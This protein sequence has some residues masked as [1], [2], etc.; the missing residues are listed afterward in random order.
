MGTRTAQGAVIATRKDHPHAYGDK[1][2]ITA[3]GLR[4][5]GSSPRVWG[6]EPSV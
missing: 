1:L 3:V 6:Q 5:A 4:D 2:S